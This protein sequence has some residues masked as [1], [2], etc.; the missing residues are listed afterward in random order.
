[1]YANDAEY[2]PAATYPPVTLR[3]SFATTPEPIGKLIFDPPRTL[4]RLNKILP[5]APMLGIF[6][7]WPRTKL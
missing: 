3:S 1:M 2:I 5:V 7:S 6:L 4:Y